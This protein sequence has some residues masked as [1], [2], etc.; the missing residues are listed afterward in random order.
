MKKTL[1]L[2]VAALL[3][4]LFLFGCAPAEEA[5]TEQSCEII[6]RVMLAEAP[7]S[8][9]E[10]PFHWYLYDGNRDTGLGQDYEYYDANAMS[11]LLAD[12]YLL[13]DLEWT[14]AAIVRMEGARAFEM[15]VLSVPQTEQKKVVQTWQDYL[16]RRRATFTGYAPDQAA[17]IDEAKILTLGGEVALLI[18]EDVAA[19]QR[20]LEQCYGEGA[21]ASGVPEF[22]MPTPEPPPVPATTVPKG[23]YPYTDPGTDDMTVCDTSAI[24]TAWQ[25]GDA[26]ALSEQD[27]RVLERAKEVLAETLT[28]G[29]TDLE[30]EY[31][32]YRWLTCNVYYDYRHYEATGCPRSSYE[33][34][35][36]LLEGTGVCLGYATTFQLF[37][38]MCDIECITVTGAAFYSKEAHAWNQVR[39]DG[40]WY[41]VDATWDMNPFL[42]QNGDPVYDYFNVTSDWMAESDHQWEYAVVPEAVAE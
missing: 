30:K 15:A 29:M 11:S 2:P 16:L 18:C 13:E 40:N 26:S 8:G 37:M 4:L 10:L 19:A 7:E 41:C 12:L 27:G 21:F 42:D 14:D 24:L 31:A 34:A 6:T 23:R 38:D 25:T 22:L 36:P 17:L 39:L 1:C 32:L 35:G 3:T 33:P 28:D 9:E 5:S 20:E